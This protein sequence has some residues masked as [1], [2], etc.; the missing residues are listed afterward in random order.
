MILTCKKE[1]YEYIKYD[2]EINEL[3]SGNEILINNF[4]NQFKEK[5]AIDKTNVGSKYADPFFLEWNIP[6]AT[7]PYFK[8]KSNNC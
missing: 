5:I 4:L 3:F 1:D 6:L 8:H 2:R 7:I